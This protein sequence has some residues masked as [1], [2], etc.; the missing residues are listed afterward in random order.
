MTKVGITIAVDGNGPTTFSF[1]IGKIDHAFIARNN[2]EAKITC[3]PTTLKISKTIHYWTTIV[4]DVDHTARP[5]LKVTVKNVASSSNFIPLND[6]DLGGHIG[7]NETRTFVYVKNDLI[8][9]NVRDED[10]DYN[11][12]IRLKLVDEK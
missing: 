5:L 1:E 12:F 11:E 3:S 6:W 10:I 4:A 7:E 8:P 2:K 9:S